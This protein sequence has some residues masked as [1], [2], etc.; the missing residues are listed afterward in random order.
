MIQIDLSGKVVV[1]TG[2]GSGL[3]A[4]M[5]RKLGAAGAGVVVNYSRNAAGAEEVAA[6]IRGAGGRALPFRAD[7]TRDDE[8]RA[9]FEA[10][11]RELGPVTIVVNNAGREERLAPPPEL[12]WS[13][14]QRMID[15][16][17]KAIHLT[18]TTAHP[19]M[20]QAGWGRIINIGSVALVRPFPGSAAYSAAKGAMLGV[21]RAMAA[22]LGPDGITVNLIAPGWIPVE[23][24][25]SA[26]DEALE[27]LLRETP[28]GR[29]GTPEDVAGAVLFFASDLSAFVSGTQLPVNG[30]HLFF[31]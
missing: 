7:V 28:A 31:P 5:A 20:Q 2:S 15:L 6:E 19:D 13:D 9:M 1:I 3:G 18:T 29:I 26:P 23:R 16:N 11:R 21:T 24:H 8:V 17:L 4:E 30:A 12:Q 22:E 27:K 25:A 10:A 14:Y